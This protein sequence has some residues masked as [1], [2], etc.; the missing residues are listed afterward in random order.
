MSDQPRVEMAK[1]PGNKYQWVRWLAYKRDGLKEVLVPSQAKWVV[2]AI[3]VVPVIVLLLQ[4]VAPERHQS[5]IQN[6]Q[7]IQGTVE[8][9]ATAPGLNSGT[10]N[11]TKGRGMLTRYLGPQII[12]RPFMDSLPPGTMVKAVLIS[13]AS[14]GPVRAELVDPVTINGET[15]AEAG[16][17]LLGFGNSTE[18][19]L[20]ITFKKLVSKDGAVQSIKAQA[21][22]DEDRIAGL[23]GSKVGK[24]A[25][26]VAGAIGLGFIGGFAEGLQKTRGEG[27][28]QIKE[29]SLEN[30]AL[31]GTA[32]AA[33]DQSQE[34]S[35][36]LRNE[37]PIIE[38]KAG[39]HIY[40]IFE[41][42]PKG[43][44]DE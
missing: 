19:R 37:K 8:I 32:K 31:N 17:S 3:I 13:G 25:L 2:L 5:E 42:T 9:P 7:S 44:E 1:D 10:K 29:P 30:A 36:S 18:E 23:K 20:Y 26:K 11:S 35:N 4:P 14:N 24:A 33:M 40:V 16:S 43:N 34:M 12:L 27:G 21:C 38:V 28:V 41:P 15:L 22:D 39:A 6:A